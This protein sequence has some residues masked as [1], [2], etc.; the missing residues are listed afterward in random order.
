VSEDLV[1]WTIYDRP[2]DYPGGFVVVPWTIRGGTQLRG[3]SLRAGTLEEARALVP[4]GLYCLGR[5]P[6]DDMAIAES[7]I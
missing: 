7:W 2:L 5:D 1:I 6:N 4:A 3:D